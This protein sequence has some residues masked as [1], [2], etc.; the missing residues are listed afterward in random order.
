MNPIQKLFPRYDSKIQPVTT[1]RKI[2]GSLSFQILIQFNLLLLPLW[3][4]IMV[5]GI[6]YRTLY[7]PIDIYY[8]ELVITTMIFTMV[9]SLRLYLSFFGNLTEQ[10]SDI[11]GSLM[12]MIFPI[13]IL[14]VNTFVYGIILELEFSCNV[15]Y[16]AFLL[17]EGIAGYNGCKDLLNNQQQ[18]LFMNNQYAQFSSGQYENFGNGQG[19]LNTRPI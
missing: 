12:L 11:T 15:I 3:V 9:E 17:M 1:S 13:L 8:Y 10:V 2:L 14:V 4:I 7:F 18:S 5:V 6:V 16:I 19:I